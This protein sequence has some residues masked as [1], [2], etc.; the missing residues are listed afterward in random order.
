M[1]SNN[2]GLNSK[3][4]KQLKQMLRER[5]MKVSGRK[6]ELINRLLSQPSS[7]TIISPSIKPITQFSFQ[8][9][10]V[11]PTV[12]PTIQISFQPSVHPVITPPSVQSS[13]PPSSFQ[14]SSQQGV[15]Y[16]L[17]PPEF[18]P[19]TK[20]SCEGYWDIRSYNSQ[21]SYSPDSRYLPIPSNKVWSEKQVWMNKAKAVE[22]YIKVMSKEDPTGSIKY[23]CYRGMSR[24]RLCDQFVGNCEYQH[25]GMCWPSN[26][27]EHYIGYHNVMPTK[28]FYEFIE[29]FYRLHS[30]D[31]KNN[32]SSWW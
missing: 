6:A 21:S 8:P 10:S 20:L 3:T 32:K 18:M 12:Q 16:G 29:N 30:L 22:E 25:K 17:S 24:C 27:I 23:Q 13:L 14:S 2:V 1:S 19:P 11:Q 31:N 28:R 9:P 15:Q 7:G 4:V 5:G 26:Y